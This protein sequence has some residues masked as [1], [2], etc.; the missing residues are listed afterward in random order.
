MNYTKK[1]LEV[2]QQ[3]EKAGIECRKWAIEKNEL[4]LLAAALSIYAVVD[5]MIGLFLGQNLEASYQTEAKRLEKG[6]RLSCVGNRPAALV[7]AAIEAADLWDEVYDSLRVQIVESNGCIV[8]SINGQVACATP[9]DKWVEALRKAHG[10][11]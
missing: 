7:F 11:P 6:D 5:Q 10:V 9:V 1:L 3:A 8:I 2:V 4:S